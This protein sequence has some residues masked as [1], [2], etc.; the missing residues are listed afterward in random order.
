M[1]FNKFLAL[2]MQEIRQDVVADLAY[3]ASESYE[4]AMRGSAFQD[5]TG[6]LRSSMGWA[7]LEDGV[8]RAS[9]GFVPRG[10]A[11]AKGAR[12]G[13][14]TLHELP[15]RSG[16]V[17][18]LIAGMHYASFVESKGFDVMTRGELLMEDMLRWYIRQA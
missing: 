10:E 1:A 3:L 7:V 5:R 6:A 12:Q 17:A 18:V 9:G 13:R 8:V 14:Q 11:G 15:R 4:E 2:R 16:F